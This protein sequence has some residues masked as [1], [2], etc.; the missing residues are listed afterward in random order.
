MKPT[1]LNL[2][3]GNH[4]IDGWENVDCR[5]LP[6]V[7]RV[8]DLNKKRWPWKGGNVEEIITS[9]ALEHLR[10][11]LAALN[12]CHRILRPGGSITVIV[13]HAAG[14]MANSPG[15]YSVF[16]AMWFEAF[17]CSRDCQYALDKLWVK[18]ELKM[19]IAHHRHYAFIPWTARVLMRVWEKF[20]NK[21]WT[22]RMAWEMVGIFPPGE[23]KWTAM[24][25]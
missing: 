2:G 1:K 6:G 7:D 10:D 15:H 11:P 3:S 5:Q 9:H 12:E 13:P 4:L 16:S 14:Y 20:W 22:R 17:S 25:K 19:F 23:I 18:Q 24:K 8:V 21:T